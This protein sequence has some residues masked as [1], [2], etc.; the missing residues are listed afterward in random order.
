[1]VLQGRTDAEFLMHIENAPVTI[2]QWQLEKLALVTMRQHVLWYVPGVPAE[3]QGKL[4][5]RCYPTVQSAL[6]DL[7]ASLAP[8]ARV[9]VIPDG[10]Y[11]LGRALTHELAIG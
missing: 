6:A 11:V 8:G 10:P 1:M 5:G 4:W 7:A 3:H 2:D 9:A